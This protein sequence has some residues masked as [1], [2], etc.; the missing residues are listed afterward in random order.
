MYT[1]AQDTAMWYWSANTPFWQLSTHSKRDVQYQVFFANMRGCMNV[2]TYSVRTIFREPKFLGCIRI[3]LETRCHD[4]SLFYRTMKSLRKTVRKF[5][6]KNLTHYGRR[7]S[8]LDFRQTYVQEKHYYL[9]ILTYHW[10]R[11]WHV[12]SCSLTY[13]LGQLRIGVRVKTKGLLIIFCSRQTKQWNSLPV[14]T[15]TGTVSGKYLSY[16]T[17]VS[18]GVVKY[19]DGT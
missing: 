10:T 12:Y 5:L 8:T 9:R 14:T 15:Q 13:S 18:S 1:W 11:W 4:I 7:K 2:R 3:F 6:T 16:Y 17:V 19:I